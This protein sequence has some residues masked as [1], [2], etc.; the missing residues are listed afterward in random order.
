MV[1]GSPDIVPNK[2]KSPLLKTLKQPQVKHWHVFLYLP[3]IVDYIRYVLAI[4]GMYYAFVKEQWLYFIVYYFFAIVM[5]A[6]DGKLAR[7]FN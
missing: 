4:K 3:N 5:D 7:M 1:T 6:F 2:D